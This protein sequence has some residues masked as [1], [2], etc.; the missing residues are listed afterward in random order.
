MKILLMK[1]ILTLLFLSL[2]LVSSCSD[3]ES[4]QDSNTPSSLQ[5]KSSDV[6]YKRSYED[7]VESM[8]KELAEK[9][10]ELSDLEKKII[11]LKEGEEDST[12]TFII[13]NEKNQSY[14][15]TASLKVKQVK[16][17]VLR[18]KINSL[19]EKS[20]SKYNGNVVVHRNLLNTIDKKNAS[21]ND[22]HLLLKITRTLPIIEK[23]QSSNKPSN[24]PINGFL[25]EL[26]NTIKIADTL[27]KK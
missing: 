25:N 1:T 23:Y 26:N 3:N 12:K 9:T 18:A 2:F 19:I 16:D 11:S 13:Y 24:K 27:S 7:L 15:N 5:T 6:I 10:P 21:L 4:S 17:S 14:Y 20:L 8:Y 22:L